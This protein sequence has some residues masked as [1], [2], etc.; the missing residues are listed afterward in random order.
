MAVIS[1]ESTQLTEN[2]FT[3]LNDCGFYLF[4]KWNELSVFCVN[5]GASSTDG[6]RN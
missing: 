5:G 3:L 6:E 4:N 1:W 2:L